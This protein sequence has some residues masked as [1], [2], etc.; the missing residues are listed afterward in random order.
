MRFCFF[1]LVLFWFYQLNAQQVSWN[2]QLL[3]SWN[4]SNIPFNGKHRTYNEVWG[5]AI[6]GGEYGVIGSREGTYII[7]V[8]YPEYPRLVRFIPGAAGDVTN[9]DYHD[10][11]GYLYMVADQ[12]ESS[13]QIV[14][15]HDL[16]DSVSVIYDSDTLFNRSHNIF[17]DSVAARLYACS[18][19]KGDSTSDLQIYSLQIPDQPELLLDYDA[20]S[21]FH[22]VY[23]KNDT[24]F[25][26]NQRE[27][28]FVYDFT[29]LDKPE[30]IAALTDYPE[31]G[32][33]HSGWVSRNGKYYFFADET[34]GSD[35]K[36]CDITDITD[37]EV[38]N[39]FN[40]G[41]AED[42]MVHNVIVMG[43]F[44]YVSYYHDG[45]QLFDIIDPQFPVKA[46][47]YD[48]YLG[49]DHDGGKGAWGVYPFL[50]S[51][52]V[53]ISDREKGLYVLDASQALEE[54][55]RVRPEPRFDIFPNPFNTHLTISILEG[56]EITSVTIYDLQGRKLLEDTPV[57][58]DNTYR[59]NAVSSLSAGVYIVRLEGRNAVMTKRLVKSF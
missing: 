53:L 43:D 19:K 50:P 12:G 11:A 21:A 49:S 37:I 8:T 35:I 59:W 39:T 30:V 23:V 56:Q 46:G 36:V 1:F 58:S 45:F 13:L 9:R 41:V 22:D 34:P 20:V 15:L 29:D 48:T 54:A 55:R 14:D 51:G 33:N 24:A 27:G 42:A 28:L 40:S 5:F 38:V 4:D 25:G 44:L 52:V 3:S 2:V 10:Y 31:K 16:P 18:V 6:N 26:N 32:Y 7:E 17:I 47:F 57:I